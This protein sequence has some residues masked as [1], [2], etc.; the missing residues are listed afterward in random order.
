MSTVSVYR[1][2][3]FISTALFQTVQAHTAGYL[4]ICVV[5]F[6]KYEA[7]TP[8]ASS[9]YFV[10]RYIVK[11]YYFITHPSRILSLSPAKREGDGMYDFSFLITN[12]LGL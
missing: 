3:S 4:V 6:R 2:I 7:T 5:V 9:P 1:V 10:K 12:E 11:F 8:K